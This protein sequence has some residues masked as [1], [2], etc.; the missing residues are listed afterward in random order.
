MVSAFQKTTKELLDLLQT[1]N[2]RI[3]KQIMLIKHHLNHLLS[4]WLQIRIQI[5]FHQDRLQELA[6]KVGHLRTINLMVPKIT[7][8]LETM[9]LF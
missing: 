1:S 8:T 5:N 6:K 2:H 3:D 7:I 9:E 4:I